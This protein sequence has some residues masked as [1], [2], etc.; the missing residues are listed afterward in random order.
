M[1]RIIK[2]LRFA[3]RLILWLSK[4]ITSLYPIIQAII[5]ALQHLRKGDLNDA[6]S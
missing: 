4:A 1:A 3:L 2:T 5:N 6:H